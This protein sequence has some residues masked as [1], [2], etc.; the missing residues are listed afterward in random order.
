M[1]HEFTQYEEAPEAEPS[2]SRG[3]RRP[4]GKFTS[5]G[6]LDPPAPYRRPRSPSPIP[7]LSWP[8][9]LRVCAIII[10]AGLGAA[11]VFAITHF[12]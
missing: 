9:W 8:V 10:L 3:G 12:H 1:P 5:A 7:A 4:P 6:V 11:I 2:S